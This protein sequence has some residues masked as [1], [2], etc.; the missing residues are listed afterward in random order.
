MRGYPKHLNERADYEYVRTHFPKAMWEKDFEALLT[1]EKEWYN[2]GELDGNGVEDDTHKVVVDE[3]YDKKYQYE[4]RMNT[5]AK[6]YRLGYTV[7]DVKAIL[8]EN[9]TAEFGGVDGI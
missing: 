6:I 7:E 2:L 4:Y 3:K 5:C 8:R 1:T 9:D